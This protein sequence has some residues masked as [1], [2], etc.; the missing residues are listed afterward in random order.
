MQ[1][2]N[3]QL[4]MNPLEA[5]AWQGFVGVVQNLL[6]NRR[7]ANFAEIVQSVLDAYQRVGPKMSIKVHFLHNHLDRFPENC[8]DVSDEQ[9]EPFHQDIKEMEARYQGRWDARMMAD[10]CWSIKRDKPDA[11]HSRQS[12]KRKFL[13][14]HASCFM[15]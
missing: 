6:G 11:I 10:Y 13:Q 9:G 14:K 5:D 1:D 4:S 8:G 12:R 7:A 15:E 3:F 2:E